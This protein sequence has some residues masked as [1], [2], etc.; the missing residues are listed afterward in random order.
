[1]KKVLIA[2]DKPFASSAVK[3]MRKVIE[4]AGYELNVLERYTEK[5]QLLQAVKEVDALIM[6]SDIVDTEVLNAAEKLKI[7]VRAGAGYD[8]IDLESATSHDVCVMNTPGQ[9]SNAVAELAIGMLIYAMRNFYSGTSGFELKGKNIGILAYGHVGR[10]VARIAKGLK[11]NVFAYDTF[12]PSASMEEDGVQ[13][14]SDLEELFRRCQI[15]SLHIPLTEETIG[16]VNRKLMNLMPEHAVLINTAR[17][18]IMNEDDLLEVFNTRV[19]F[20]YVSDIQPDKHDQFQASFADRY[21]STPKKMGAQTAEAN[22]NAGIAAAEEV[23]EYLLSGNEQFR[24]N[25]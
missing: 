11:M 14:I 17:K 20:K 21:Y 7:A 8:N 25:K 19:D 16:S 6:R 22:I 15:V 1:M 9:N 4:A 24:V 12:C 5:E 10:N 23:V 13:C 3:E 18:E 2:T